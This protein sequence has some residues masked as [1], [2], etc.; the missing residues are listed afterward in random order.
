MLFKVVWFI[1][2]NSGWH[3]YKKK[4]IQILGHWKSFISGYGGSVV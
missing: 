3:Y 1:L 4:D 2:W